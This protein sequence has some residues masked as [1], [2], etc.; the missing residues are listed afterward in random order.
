MDEKVT[1]G[2]L[3]YLNNT[4]WIVLKHLEQGTPIPERVANRRNHARAVLSVN[5]T[6]ANNADA[7]YAITDHEEAFR[8]LIAD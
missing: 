5:E 1:A 8:S 3:Q 6:H 2:A 7:F 4:D